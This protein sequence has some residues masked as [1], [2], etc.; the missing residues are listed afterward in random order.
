MD[1]F[2]NSE[3]KKVLRIEIGRQTLLKAEEE[4]R[5]PHATRIQRG[6]I[7]V[8]KWKLSDI[9]EIGKKYGKLKKPSNQKVIS[10]FTGKGGVLKSTLSFN[11]GRTL[12]LNGVKTLLIGLDIQ[13][14]ITTLALGHSE[15]E[16]I[17]TIKPT[18]GLYDFFKKKIELEKII[19]TTNLPTLSILPESFE[20]NLLEKELRSVTQRES[21][22]K[23]K[24][25]P[26]LKSYDVIIFDNS[27]NWNLL[28][29]NSLVASNIVIAPI[30]CE[31]GTYQALAKNLKAL[32]EFKNEMEI[33][34]DDYIMIPT[35]LENNKISKQILGAYLSEYGKQVTN[36]T[37]RR[38][39][40]GQESMAVKK[41]IFEYS[42]NSELANDYDSLFMEVWERINR[43]LKQ[44]H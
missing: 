23:K 17:K 24:L 36:G 35:L 6:N 11:F 40:K 16:D 19:K 22:F 2:L 20:L 25:I 34:W 5:I 9:P 32:L 3:I 1:L 38:T 7:S 8:R 13:E 44:W 43:T 27:P 37:L 41:S 10:F 12:A 30:S 39:V 42:A 4:G 28:I 31:I 29:E 14:S 21:F 18:L 15:Y 33:I 26:L